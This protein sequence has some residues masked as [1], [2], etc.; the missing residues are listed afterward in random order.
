LKVYLRRLPIAAPSQALLESEY[1][2]MLACVRCGLCLTSCP[3]YVLTGNEAEGPRGR[4]AMMRALTE[5]YIELTPD[6]VHH[7]QNCLVCDACSAVCPVGIHMGD[8]QVAFRSAVEPQM[9]RTAR[10]RW[11]RSVVFRR[12]FQ[13][14]KTF[15]RL[16]K[17][18][19]LYQRSGLRSVA[20]GLGILRL[21]RLREAEALL[22]SGAGAAAARAPPGA[23]RGSTPNAGASAFWLPK[24][25][26]P[27]EVVVPAEPAPPRNV[28][29]SQ[30]TPSATTSSVARAGA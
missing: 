12:V 10:Q 28:P 4:I 1:P 8:M 23:S 5:G 7:E 20:R 29:A 11:L 27:A 3:T 26:A 25:G 2:D 13:D 24:A 15:R 14:M 19:R 22:R 30:V 17:L 16:A 21:F 18:M 9:A 6:L